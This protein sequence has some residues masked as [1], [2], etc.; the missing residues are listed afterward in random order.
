MY[1]AGMEAVINTLGTVFLCTRNQSQRDKNINEL[2]KCLT[3]LI[4]QEN[5]AIKSAE[6]L[7]KIQAK[8]DDYSQEGHMM[9][10]V[11]GL[12]AKAL[13]KV[14]EPQLNVEKHE[15]MAKFESRLVKLINNSTENR[16]WEENLNRDEMK[17]TQDS[18]EEDQEERSTLDPVTME[19]I[20]DPVKN[21]ICGHSYERKSIKKLLTKSGMMCP[22]EGCQNL[23]RKGDI[24]DDDELRRYIE[25]QNSE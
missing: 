12:F 18:G 13:A 1:S 7:M 16:K 10:D 20:V 8:L 23:L 17:N 3:E 11:D 21:S 6:A 2:R 14:K 24:V 9:K 15:M 19:E 22:A 4:T 25:G 5:T